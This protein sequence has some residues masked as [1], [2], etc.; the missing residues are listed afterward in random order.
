MSRYRTSR[1]RRGGVSQPAKPC[2]G[3]ARR[4]EGATLGLVGSA[5]RYVSTGQAVGGEGHR[6]VRIETCERGHV[7]LSAA[8]STAVHFGSVPDSYVKPTSSSAAPRVGAYP[9]STD[10]APPVGTAPVR[11]LRQ[12]R[13]WNARRGTVPRRGKGGLQGPRRSRNRSRVIRV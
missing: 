9:A 4:G 7:R 2:G 13:P 8:G 6:T 1:S 11:E 3:G 10:C 5:T 12:R